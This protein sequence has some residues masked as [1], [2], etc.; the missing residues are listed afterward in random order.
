[1]AINSSDAAIVE[2]NGARAV[3]GDL[4]TDEGL[5][6]ARREA[7]AADG[8]IHAVKVHRVT[9]TDAPAADAAKREELHHAKHSEWER[10][11]ELTLDM[12]LDALAGTN[13]PL[14]F[15]SSCSI[16]G[17]AGEKVIDESS[18]LAPDSRYGGWRAQHE[19][20]VIEAASR[21][22]RTVALRTA[23]IY[24]PHPKDMPL[25]RPHPA[26]M[27]GHLMDA[28]AVGY[29]EDG[30]S[31]GTAVHVDDYAELF[32]LALE[33]APPGSVYI[34]GCEDY[35]RKTHALAM[36]HAYG[37]GG[38]IR[39][40]TMEETRKALGDG[41]VIELFMVNHRTSSRKAMEELG[42]R[43]KA[44]SMMEC[45]LM[46]ERRR[47]PALAQKADDSAP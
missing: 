28:D 27:H 15:S 21:G 2:K 30:S 3:V 10:V 1:M 20:K 36:S 33:K 26:Q 16:Y 35:T 42:W 34:G 32:V 37:Y 14:V 25:G 18:P 41:R 29:L 45:A 19:R 39:S 23:K 44:P 24:G 8:V 47:Y 40:W 6:V 7:V 38:R 9:Q 11:D 22:I 31:V 43:P 13:K 12:L 4:T 17:D 5:A 46:E